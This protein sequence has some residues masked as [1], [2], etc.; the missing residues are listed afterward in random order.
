M[1]GNE[2]DIHIKNV[3]YKRDFEGEIAED[4]L[5]IEKYDKCP[6]SSNEL[7][8][9]RGI[10]VGNIFQL[11]TKYSESLNVKFLDEDGKEKYFYM[12]S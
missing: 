2:K 9:A 11:G 7:K 3:N 6:L 5:M 10:E 8:F 12:G 4:L 1:G